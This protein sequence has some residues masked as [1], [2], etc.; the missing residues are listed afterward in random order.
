MSFLNQEDLPVQGPFNLILGLL[1][2][3]M[4]L[5]ALLPSKD[6]PGALAALLGGACETQ[7]LYVPT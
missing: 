5:L 7:D 1:H 3:W 4:V 2:W 6:K